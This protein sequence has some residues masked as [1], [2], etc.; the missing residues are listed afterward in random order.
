[1]LSNRSFV[2]CFV[3]FA[4][5]QYIYTFIYRFIN[6]YFLFSL[7]IVSLRC[8]HYFTCSSVFQL[9]AFHYIKSVSATNRPQ[10]I[11]RCITE[12][13]ENKNN[14]N[15][16][17]IINGEQIK[18]THRTFIHDHVHIYMFFTSLLMDNHLAEYESSIRS[19]STYS[20]SF[21]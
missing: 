9:N 13:R 18:N 21:K 3:L 16:K 2:C 4:L 6:F 8:T 1:M 14:N 12:M 19:V 15:S 17:N 5:L 11:I 20:F 10:Q 7:A